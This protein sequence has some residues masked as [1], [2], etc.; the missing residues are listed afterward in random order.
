MINKKSP[1]VLIIGP[2]RVGKSAV[3]KKLA[4]D[5]NMVYL[6]PTKFF[7]EIF[8]KVADFEE[9]MLTW[10]EEHP[11]EEEPNPEENPEE[12]EQDETKKKQKKVKK[13]ETNYLASWEPEPTKNV[14]PEVDSVL[15]EV[16]LAVYNDLIN[17]QGVSEQ[18]MQRM[19][20]YILHSDLAISRGVVIDM[21]SNITPES[22]DPESDSRSFVEKIL[23]D[24]YGPVEVDYV[25]ELS[26]IHI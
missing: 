3:S 19:Y 25:V 17:G 2:P 20:M 16:E 6:E 11:K 10:D 7:E 26:L 24:F 22:D 12:G 4:E 1:V 5:L 14:K 18:N 9:K 8:K 15:N 21:N 13:E 23:T